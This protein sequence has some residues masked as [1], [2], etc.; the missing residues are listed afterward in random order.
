M[1]FGWFILPIA[2]LDGYSYSRQVQY[3]RNAIMTMNMIFI[4]IFDWFIL[5]TANLDEYNYRRQVQ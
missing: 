3:D 4:I 1:I 2:N 5:P